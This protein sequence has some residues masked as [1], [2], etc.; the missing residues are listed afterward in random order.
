MSSFPTVTWSY[1]CRDI[2]DEDQKEVAVALLEGAEDAELFAQYSALAQNCIL[3]EVLGDGSEM[4]PLVLKN[5]EQVSN[6]YS[7]QHCTSLGFDH[8]FGGH[9]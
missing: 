7:S 3:K 6:I 2:G 8:Y 5:A 1:L 4:V 9:L